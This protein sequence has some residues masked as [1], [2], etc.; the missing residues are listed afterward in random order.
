MALACG[1]RTRPWPQPPAL[2]ELVHPA[3]SDE[4]Q[5]RRPRVRIA[6]HGT[7]SRRFPGTREQRRSACRRTRGADGAL[8]AGA[9]CGVPPAGLS[10]APSING[11]QFHKPNGA[12]LR[13]ALPVFR[14]IILRNAEESV[15]RGPAHL[16]CTC[17]STI[18][19][20]LRHFPLD[21]VLCSRWRAGAAFKSS[22]LFG[23]ARTNHYFGAPPG[24]E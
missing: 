8:I 16:P 5:Q 24:K 14:L 11:A 15:W 2:A 6:P 3:P 9:H 22:G 7:N 18:V 20:S 13:S 1:L 19:P 17:P 10:R 4:L 12:S 23:N 21:A